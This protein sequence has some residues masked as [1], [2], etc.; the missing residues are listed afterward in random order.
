LLLFPLSSRKKATNTP[1]RRISCCP[2][3]I[4]TTIIKLIGH[5]GC[6][7]FSSSI[8]HAATRRT[9]VTSIIKHIGHQSRKPFLVGYYS[10]CYPSNN[11]YIHHQTHWASKKKALSRHILS[12]ATC[13]CPSHILHPLSNTLRIKAESPALSR[14]ILSRAIDNF[15]VRSK[16]PPC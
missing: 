3:H 9:I 4:Y 14:Q 5:Q 12:P 10:C 6:S 16:P 8:I 1:R 13:C 11:C 2:S 15:N 7:P